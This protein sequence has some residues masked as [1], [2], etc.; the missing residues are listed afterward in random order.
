ME[1]IF[2]LQ[3]NVEIEEIYGS[4][5]PNANPPKDSKAFRMKSGAQDFMDVETYHVRLPSWFRKGEVSPLEFNCM[6]E[7]IQAIG[8]EEYVRNR[9]R[10]IGSYEEGNRPITIGGALALVDIDIEMMLKIFSFIERWGLINYRSLIEKEI[11]NLRSY[12]GVDT[13]SMED[14]PKEECPKERVDVKEQLEKAACGC[15]GKATFFTRSLVFRC[16]KCIDDGDYPQEVLRSDFIPI[17]ESLVKQMW[18]KKEEFLLLE[19]ISKF[20]DEWESV[21]QYVQTKTKEQCIFHFLRLPILENTLSK[22]DLSIGKLFETAENPIMC[23]VAFVCGIVHPK[24]AS[25]CAKTAIKYISECSQD[26]V[27]QHILDAGRRKAH[28]QRD[29]ERRKIER[30]KNVICE[31]LLNKIKMKIGTYKELYLSTQRVRSE[32]IALRRG[33]AEDINP[34]GDE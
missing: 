33:L 31:A 2:P 30:L 25:E 11:R 5:R 28:E 32:L 19:G 10:I 8:K 3:E 22:A 17:T 12:D 23:I 14:V 1:N 15:G 7:V 26:S 27:I 6:G 13:K 29:L 4:K 18:S 9:D 24:V 34:G 20:G 16:T 21:S